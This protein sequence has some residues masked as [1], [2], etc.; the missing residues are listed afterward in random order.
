M[1]HIKINGY[2]VNF[3]WDSDME[4]TKSWCSGYPTIAAFAETESESLASLYEA[5]SEHLSTRL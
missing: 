4:L 3:A 5:I 2:P 1:I